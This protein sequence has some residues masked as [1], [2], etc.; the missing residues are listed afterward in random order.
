MLSTECDQIV[1]WGIIA[2]LNIGTQELSA[3]AESKR[4]EAS[5]QVG[6]VLDLFIGDWYRNDE[7][8][9]NIIN[10][11]ADKVDLIVDVAEETVKL[12]NVNIVSNLNTK[13]GL[14]I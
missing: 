5:L 7:L 6:I 13:R 14:W 1:H 9:K 2:S 3:L 11:L 8:N 10:L 4:V 12:I